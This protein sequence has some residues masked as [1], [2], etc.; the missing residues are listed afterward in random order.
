MKRLL[1]L[2]HAKAAT[3]SPRA[4]DSD[5]PL[6]ERGRK[7]APRVGIEM[8]HRRYLPD[9]V[10]CSTALRTKETWEHVMPELDGSPAVRFLDEL[11][12]ASAKAI[13]DI[14]R[15]KGDDYPVVL[16]IGH[17]PGLEDCAQALSRKPQSDQ[18]RICA[19]A[20]AEKFP[21]CALAVLDFEVPSWRSIAPGTGTLHDFIRP[22]SLSG[23]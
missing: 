14:V 15:K 13:T 3:G 17:N 12:L 18:E 23:G 7:D 1:L 20:L 11:Y 10:L 8:Q 2:R 16:V 22:K 5:R 9:L 6:N 19:N 4:S 21:T